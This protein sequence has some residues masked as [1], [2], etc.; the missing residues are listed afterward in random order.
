MDR[1][2]DPLQIAKSLWD[3]SHAAQPAEID[4][5][6][7]GP[8]SLSAAPDTAFSSKNETNRGDAST[9][10]KGFAPA[11]PHECADEPLS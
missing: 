1:D 9:S 7:P 11:A 4:V 3:Q 6:K 5:A 10:E 8:S 2:V